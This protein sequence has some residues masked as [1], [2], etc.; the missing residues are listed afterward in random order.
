VPLSPDEMTLLS[1]LAP[2]LVTAGIT[3]VVNKAVGVMRDRLHMDLDAADVKA[4]HDA[5]DTA[6]GILMGKL[7]R[8]DLTAADMHAGHTA[9]IATAADAR[10]AVP[11]AADGMNVDVAS[12]VRMVLGRIYLP[13]PKPVVATTTVVKEPTNV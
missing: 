11:D 9:V 13:Q 12:M 7:A 3:W 4:L 5:A 8:G 1:V 2:T 10:N 6:A